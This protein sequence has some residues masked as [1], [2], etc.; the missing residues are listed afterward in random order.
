[1]SILL[2]SY[3]LVLKV[4]IKR[5]E[6]NT[7]WTS[8]VV[9]FFSVFSCVFCSLRKVNTK[10]LIVVCLL[11]RNMLFAMDGK[12]AQQIIFPDF[13]GHYTV[14]YQDFS[15]L[16]SDCPDPYTLKSERQ[17]RFT[18]FY[19]SNDLKGLEPYQAVDP[20][21]HSDL[22]K[23]LRTLRVYRKRNAKPIHVP[24]PVIFFETGTHMI[25]ENY[26]SLVCGLVSDGYIVVGMEHT[27]QFRNTE[28]EKDLLEDQQNVTDLCKQDTLF[29][30]DLLSKDPHGV[31]L[32][33]KS[34]GVLG[35][36][37]GGIVA[38]KLI[39]EPQFQAAAFCDPPKITLPKNQKPLL[40]LFAPQE[41][42]GELWDDVDLLNLNH[43]NQHKKMI[44]H[45]G[46]EFFSNI[47][48]FK[49]ILP[50]LS[51]HDLT[52][53][54]GNEKGTKNME[55]IFGEIKAFFDRYLRDH[56]QGQEI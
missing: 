18:V 27:Y 47:A 25:P 21:D 5:Q 10:L 31:S 43:Q 3:W 46:H 9:R 41:K 6:N 35:H 51:T 55:R 56:D 19:P 16:N 40:Y 42:R 13:Q 52:D 14:G 8:F 36:S 22:G 12:E 37:L 11:T 24:C 54:L 20:K 53:V 39:Q 26:L 17:I 30:L 1:M 29:V 23:A 34:I 48:I 32:N 44:E 49:E 2:F 33:L 38:Q 4:L 15:T 7:F 50:A 45:G 28:D